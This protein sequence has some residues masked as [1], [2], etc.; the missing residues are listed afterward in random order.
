MVFPLIQLDSKTT[1]RHRGEDG[2]EE[3]DGDDIDGLF[4]VVV[5]AVVVV[6]VDFIASP[7]ALASVSIAVVVVIFLFSFVGMVVTPPFHGNSFADI[8]LAPGNKIT[9]RCGSKLATK[10]PHCVSTSSK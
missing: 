9:S 3:E 6:A 1:K 8:A 7:F 2:E 5:F 4:A 10:L